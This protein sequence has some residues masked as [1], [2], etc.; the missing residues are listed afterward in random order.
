V[1]GGSSL[2]IA[3]G[4]LT[5]LALALALALAGC[6]ASSHAGIP[7]R[8]GA[9][10]PELQALARRAQAG[11]AEAQL[12]LGK[13]YYEGRGVPA[14]IERA[15]ALFRSAAGG[16]GVT[17]LAYVPPAGRGQQGSWVVFSGNPGSKGL[18]EARLRLVALDP[19]AAEM[20][21][22][23]TLVPQRPWRPDVCDRL[24][25]FYSLLMGGSVHQCEAYPFEVRSKGGR[26]FVAYDLA[27]SLSDEDAARN[28][29]PTT[30]FDP[31]VL[32]ILG[33]ETAIEGSLTFLLAPATDGDVAIIRNFMPRAR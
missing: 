13:R 11:E 18:P 24:A 15:K 1:L 16:P 2:T 7:L 33:A 8:P 28:D 10:D 5:A 20:R 31:P 14:D 25:G 30:L 4:S 23:A 21:V 12:E 9:A 3:R 26:D 29:Y 22:E 17:Q 32:A 6:A 19:K 27:V